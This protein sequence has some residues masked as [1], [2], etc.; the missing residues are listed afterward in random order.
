MRLEESIKA[1]RTVDVKN[2]SS[3]Y[4]PAVTAFLIL[5][6]PLAALSSLFFIEKSTH[7]RRENGIV[8]PCVPITLQ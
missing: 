5:C 8:G 7:A 3:F 6:N 1:V 4:S 2:S